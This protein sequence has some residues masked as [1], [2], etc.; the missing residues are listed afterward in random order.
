MENSL[1]LG[2][3][4]ILT[5][6]FST[7]SNDIYASHAMG[8]DIYYECI[9]PATNTYRVTFD[10]YRDC[11]GISAP[12]SVG[13]SYTSSCGSGSITMFRV[14]AGVEVSPLCPAQINQS[15]CRGGSLP[16]VQKYTY[17]ATINNLAPCSNWVF[18]AGI[19]ARNGAIT[20]GPSGTLWV[21]AT[22]NSAVAPCNSSPTFTTIP[23]PYVCVN[24]NIN[25]N[26][27]AIDAD[28]DSL[29]FQLVQPRSSS[30]SFANFN[31]PY[32]PTYPVA[33]QSGTFNLN[34]TNGNMSFTPSQIQVGVLAVQ[35]SEYRNGILIGTTTRDIQITVLNC[36]NQSA[37]ING[38]ENISGG[39]TIDPFIARVC[40]NTTL[41]FNLTATDPDFHTLTMTSNIA[42]QIPG[43]SFIPNGS[44][45]TLGASFSWTPT[46]ADQG[47]HTFI[48]SLTDNGCPV[49]AT[50]IYGI[51]VIVDSIMDAGPDTFILCERPVQLTAVGGDTFT[52]TPSL[53]LNDPFIPNPVATNTTPTWYTV[54]SNCGADSVFVDVQGAPF[55][56]DAGQNDTTC[57]GGGVQL[58]A[59]VNQ[60]S[61]QYTYGWIQDTSLSNASIFNPNANPATSNKYYFTVSQGP[62]V[63]TDS[64]LVV[65]AQPNFIDNP[66]LTEVKCNSGSDGAINLGISGGQSPYT[67]SINGQSFVNSGFFNN[68]PAGPYNIRVK[69]GLG[70]D[71][72]YSYT[73]QEPMPVNINLVDVDSVLCPRGNNGSLEVSA[74]GGVGAYRFNLSGQST[75]SSGVFD[76][77]VR[78]NYVVVV[79]DSNNCKDSLNADVFQPAFFGVSSLLIDSAKCNGDNKGSIQIAGSGGNAP[80]RYGLNFGLLQQSGRFDSLTSATYTIRMRDRYGCDTSY[81]IKVGQPGELI[82]LG[83]TDSTQCPGG[84]DGVFVLNPSGG[85]RPYRY[86]LDG[87]SWSNQPLFTNLT[88]GLH[89][90]LVEDVNGCADSILEQVA[91]PAAIEID[92]LIIDSANCSGEASG[93]FTVVMQGGS[94]PYS[95]TIGTGLPQSS[96]QFNNLNSGNYQLQIIDIKGC[97]TSYPVVVPEPTPLNAF[98]ANMDSVK[99]YGESNGSLVIG[100]QGGTPNYQFALDNNPYGSSPFFNGLP[101][102]WYVLKAIDQN[103]CED[104]AW[105]E[106]L[107]PMPL[108]SNLSQVD[109]VTCYGDSDGSLTV[110]ATGG[111]SPFQYSLNNGSFQSTGFFDNLEADI[112]T[113]TIIDDNGCRVQGNYP[114]AQNPP[115]AFQVTAQ[116]VLCNGGTTG[117]LSVSATGNKPPYLYSINGGQFQSNGDFQNLPAGSYT[118]TVKDANN[119]AAEENRIVNQPAPIVSS[120]NSIDSVYYLYGDDGGFSLN[121]SGGTPQIMYSIDNGITTQVSPEFENLIV[122]EYSVLIEDANGCDTT[123]LV[124]VPGH[125]PSPNYGIPNVFT[126]NGDGDN[127]FFEIV[128]RRN[129]YEIETFR[130]FNRWGQ[131]IFD[132]PALGLQKWDGTYKGELQPSGNYIYL[133]KVNRV[134]GFE[135]EAETGNLLL[136][137]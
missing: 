97:D 127:D 100:A 22:L 122:G 89:S 12:S 52:W 102:G 92:A 57:S 98:L 63:I 29:V 7:K 15:R 8:A 14:G 21:Q 11:A 79:S 39:D 3:F 58:N 38:L 33:T 46:N 81:S 61:G 114:V 69:D 112:Y 132:G 101:G 121:T 137:W 25:Y 41:A 82:L 70:C 6:I 34:S 113:I 119:C 68:L 35:V 45:S 47:L 117:T 55:T 116:D 90:V 20:T 103:G 49:A 125:V 75:R 128:D 76:S 19:N 73:L 133:I 129:E 123:I 5:L 105:A 135:F 88:A 4:A 91:E 106:I 50:S 44:G 9:N 31:S 30:S 40:P 13:L 83:Q 36:S 94:Q 77:L 126:P 110:Q 74:T 78:G 42:Q 56:V 54:R 23:V 37:T 71:T 43:A 18:G 124:Y 136:L 1:R 107:E 93:S 53:G 2:V 67:F 84:D 109:S 108:G 17:Q 65:I 111:T 48:V 51:T 120:I 80:Y 24:N 72:T 59:S 104:T 99:C 62:C 85:I 10:F 26:Q 27:G 96:N 115:F 130:V 64:V 32:S 87:G 28:G 134:D 86:S 16:G 131:M 60:I 95:Y 66:T 118:I